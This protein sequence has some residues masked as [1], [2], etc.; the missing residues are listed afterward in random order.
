MDQREQLT[1]WLWRATSLAW[2]G[3]VITGVVLLVVYKPTGVS[4]WEDI[5]ELQDGSW[6]LSSGFQ[7]VHRLFALCA[8]LFPALLIVL[9]LSSRNL[10][11]VAQAVGML[12]LSLAGWIS[13]RFIAWDQLAMWA[14]TVGT[15]MQGFEPVFSDEVRFV[16]IDGSEVTL[17]EIRAWLA[18]HVLVI[19]LIGVVAAAIVRV[20]RT[21]GTGHLPDE[22][23]DVS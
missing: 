8:F 18:V 7:Q 13:G 1:R 3:L 9:N 14:V 17:R 2:L 19:P 5:Y 11:R 15:D 12:V 10:R 22:A 6:R 21:G 23:A 20:R 16:L 4:A